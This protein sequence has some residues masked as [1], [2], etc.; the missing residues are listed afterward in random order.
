MTEQASRLSE[1]LNLF[2]IVLRLLSHQ[3]GDINTLK[4]VTSSLVA[5]NEFLAEQMTGIGDKTKEY[6][7]IIGFIKKWIDEKK[8]EENEKE[9]YR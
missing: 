4:Q 6:D 8:R 2:E 5:G 1:D 7:E 9:K 3:A